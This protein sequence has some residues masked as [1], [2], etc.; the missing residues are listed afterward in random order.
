MN[1]QHHVRY[2]KKDVNIKV[3]MSIGL[4][5]IFIF[6]VILVLLSDYFTVMQEDAIYN[7]Q[8]KPE[9]VSLN[10]LHAEEKE[11][12]TTYKLIDPEKDI[13]RIPIDRAMQLVA[14]EAAK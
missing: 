3:V 4:G 13:Y 6:I 11:I 12:L 7:T 10:E 1:N 2:E 9:S 14:E 5:V 8:L